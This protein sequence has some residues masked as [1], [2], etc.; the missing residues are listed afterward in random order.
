MSSG[1]LLDI[2][3]GALN[4]PLSEGKKTRYLLGVSFTNQMMSQ[5][6]EEASRL[7]KQAGKRAS[8]ALSQVEEEGKSTK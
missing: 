1:L 8:E 2:A 4:A 3:L 6:I 5:K 7:A